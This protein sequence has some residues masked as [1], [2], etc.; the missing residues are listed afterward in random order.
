M[1]HFA[2]TPPT[3]FR[4]PLGNPSHISRNPDHAPLIP[5]MIRG[6]N[7]ARETL[8]LR[9]VPTPR[10]QPRVR[11]LT[12][13]LPDKTNP[14]P[15]FATRPNEPGAPSPA[16]TKRT[17]R[18]ITG[19]DQTNP[20]PDHRPRPNEP[21]NTFILPDQTNPATPSSSPTK[22]TRQHLH[23]PRPNEPTK[24]LEDPGEL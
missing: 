14:G 12:T 23:P 1:A 19:P 2:H 20:A 21:G 17:R 22:R 7:T 3:R 8:I 24:N 13:F 4:H 15:E 10:S 9:P 11:L 6:M 5:Q 16:P 18:P